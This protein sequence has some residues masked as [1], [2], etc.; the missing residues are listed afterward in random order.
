MQRLDSLL[1]SIT[2]Y[3]LMQ[4]YL[5][6]LFGVVLF[7]SFLKILPYNPFDI[8]ISGLYVITGCYIANQLFAH[9]FKVKTNYES[10][11]ITGLILALIIGPLPLLSNLFFLTIA[12][13]IAM[14]SKYLIAINKQ[15]IFN[16][17]AFAVVITAVLFHSGASWWIGNLPMWP[18][19]II[20]GI[21]V[22]RKIHRFNLTLGFLLTYLLFIM[23][24]NLQNII[25]L[26]TAIAIFTN[27]F[28]MS[29]ILFFS[30]VMLTEPLTSPAD[31]NLHTYY[32]IF[33]ALVF[34]MLQKFSPFSY[35]LE[36]SLLIA[37]V[38]GRIVRLK[39]D[40]KVKNKEH[41]N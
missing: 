6:F 30:I 4:Y 5:R 20:G 16:P 8:L 29:P 11:F 31:R 9:L 38:A 35:T 2:M 10:Q 15:H 27:V 7:L 39:T 14:A 22:L 13:V 33:T 24:I 41:V 32:G 37:N 17:A 26:H 23:L 18:F 40:Y 21:I 19:I 12:P 34:I 28:L 25:S 3:R 36:L 1:N